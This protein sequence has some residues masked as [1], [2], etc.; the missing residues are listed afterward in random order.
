MNSNTGSSSGQNNNNS[1]DNSGIIDA[2][3][4]L[5]DNLRKE[6]HAKFAERD[7]LY[8]FRERIKNLEDDQKKMDENL[9]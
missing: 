8:D 4:T 5:V 1:I 6:C 3:S 7:E 9:S 2:L